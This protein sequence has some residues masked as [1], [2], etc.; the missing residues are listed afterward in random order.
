MLLLLNQL[1]V[2][3]D[4]LPTLNLCIK[5]LPPERRPLRCHR[6]AECADHTDTRHREADQLG[7]HTRIIN[8]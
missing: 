4:P 3:F 7:P 8:R 6:D 1:G 5:A 2:L